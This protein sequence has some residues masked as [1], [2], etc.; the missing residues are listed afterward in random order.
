MPSHLNVRRKAERMKRFI[1]QITV[2]G[3][4]TFTAQARAGELSAMESSH[5][6]GRIFISVNDFQKIV[7]GTERN[8]SSNAQDVQNSSNSVAALKSMNSEDKAS[9]YK[10]VLPLAKNEAKALSSV[11]A[12]LNTK[13][14]AIKAERKQ[15]QVARLN[16]SKDSAKTQEKL[17]TNLL[18]ESNL[19]AKIAEAKRQIEESNIL[20]MEFKRIGQTTQ[21]VSVQHGNKALWTKH[22]LPNAVIAQN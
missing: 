5:A 2:L 16:Q 21:L 9:L 18:E 11:L 7:G 15:L 14:A 13:L 1:A 4:M 22:T 12:D 19:E 6:Q 3:M 8:L 17:F 10:K 20:V